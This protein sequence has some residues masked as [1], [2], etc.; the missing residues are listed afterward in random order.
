[1]NNN[2]SEINTLK[3]IIGNK[4]INDTALFIYLNNCL[5]N[6]IELYD[7]DIEKSTK[8]F[9]TTFAKQIVQTYTRRWICEKEKNLVTEKTVFVLESNDVITFETW[10]R[11]TINFTKA[12]KLNTDAL[13]TL[14]RTCKKRAK[15]KNF[16]INLIVS[17]SNGLELKDLEVNKT[18][19]DVDLL[20]NDDFAPIDKLLQKRLNTKN[21]KGIVLLHGLPGTGKTTYLRYLI[22]R[23]NKKIIFVSPSIASYITDP[24]FINILIENPNSILIIEDAEN[25]IMD[26]RYSGTS[27]VSNLLN[28]SDGF[29]SDCLNVQIICTFNS[30]LENV[31]QALLRKGRLIARYNF[32]KLATPKAQILSDSIGNNTF[33]TQPL[34]IA[35]VYNQGEAFTQTTEQQKTTIGFRMHTNCITNA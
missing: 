23:L 8:L 32:G 33:I 27:S 24:S 35:E 10:S 9:A 5:P 26:R 2:L 14:L 15:K 30:E 29:L 11:C 6:V 25:I 16:E 7:I 20:Y 34:T 22:G 17:E 28:I 13:V 21:D 1:M 31:D 12:S 3:S 19:L 4:Y 18:K